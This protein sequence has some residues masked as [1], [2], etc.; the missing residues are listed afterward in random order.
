MSFSNDRVEGRFDVALEITP[1]Q[2]VDT[3]SALAA[4]AESQGIDAV[5]V[6]NHFDNRDPFLTLSAIGRET[7]HLT[8]GPGVVNPYETHPV[9][10]ATQSATL[11]ESFPGRVICG[12]GAGDG[13]TLTKLDLDRERPVRRVA[14]AVETVRELTANSTLHSHRDA[15]LDGISLGYSPES[16]VPVYV[17]AQ[18]PTMLRMASELADG[19]LINGSSPTDYRAAAGAIEAGRRQRDDELG[20]LHV[21]GFACVSIADTET[22]AREAANP[23][24][25]FVAAGAPDAVIE[26]HAIDPDR[27]ETLRRCLGNGDHSA[28]YRT[29][30]P[31]MVDAFSVTGTVESVTEQ[32]RSLWADVDAVVAGS[33]L[34][35]DRHH[36]IEL[37]G[38]VTAVLRDEE[39]IAK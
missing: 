33:P 28:A 18:G 4:H 10:I 12:I 32:L 24:V 3:S 8:L 29:V 17:G 36:A 35:P 21:V 25:A 13:A 5:L 34:G 30:T 20:E 14:Q 11:A 15:T 22:A 6:S 23:P 31:Q 37:L 27:V 9:R 7:D 19:V 39:V 26:R 2:P 16:A 1:D 38:R